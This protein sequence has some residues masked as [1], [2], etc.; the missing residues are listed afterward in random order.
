MSA[1]RYSFRADFKELGISPVGRIP[2]VSG[3]SGSVEGTGARG[4]VHLDSS[5]VELALPHLFR[6]PLPADHITANLNWTR[7]VG[8][9]RI[10]TSDVVVK[11]PN[12]EAAAQLTLDVPHEGSAIIE[13][14][15]QG[16]NLEVV[17][18]PRYMPAGVM[19]RH[20][21]DWLDNA[22]VNG[23]VRKAELTLTGPLQKFP[24][25]ENEGLFLITADIDNLTLQYQ[26]G[27]MPATAL[28]VQAEFR[29]M[30]FSATASSGIVNGLAIEDAAGGIADYRDALLR[31]KGQIHGDVN[32]GLQ[33]IQQSPIGP[34][35]GGLFQ[36]L[37]GKGAMQASAS[38]SLPLKDISKRQVDIDVHIQ[39]STLGLAGSTQQASKVQG[40]FHI[41][42][43]SIVGVGVQGQFLQGTVNAISTMDNGNNV[44]VTGRARAAPLAEFLRLPSFVKIDGEMSYRFTAPGYAQRDANGHRVLFSVDS[45]LMGLQLDMPAPVTKG[46]AT[47]RSIHVDADMPDTDVMQLRG[48]MDTLRAIV[49]LQ[50]DR[51]GW[52]FDRA[53]LRVDSTA[54]A[55][56]GDSGLRIEGNLPE[57][58][59]D[60]WLRLG[61][62]AN[63]S[64][65]SSS[66]SSAVSNT[67][68]VQDILRSANLHV[69]KL[70]LYGYEW[71]DIRAILQAADD[72]WRVD[73][74]GDKAVGQINIPYA[75]DERPLTIDMDRLTLTY[76]SDAGHD[77]STKSA[78]FDPRELPALQVNV[79]DFHFGEHG[80]GMVQA[81]ASRTP[82]GLQVDNIQI[83]SESFKGNG[84]GTWM[85]AAT[86]TQ[87]GIMFAIEST[88]VR[89]SMQLLHYADFIGAKHGRLQVNLNWP[90]GIDEDLLGR[91]SG[92]MEL[93]LNDGQLLTVQPG[94][95]RM[96]GLM[97]IAELPRR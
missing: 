76:T 40:R 24:F 78:S 35:I 68:H 96:L 44:V 62:G 30:G 41:A 11:S 93:Q 56:P 74:A 71:L 57:L 19:P 28:Q 73:V 48:S 67:V 27:W 45:D 61:G 31:I 69:G 39:D 21:L 25:R 47:A 32:Q 18:A 6:T 90:G 36:Q 70:H 87:A 2:G 95:G 86:G 9:T 33:Y 46:A 84:S 54:A 42:N 64:A 63:S 10:Q 72:A 50:N 94:A 83:E 15:A 13:A 17:S 53:G 91:A 20:V 29:N 59:L 37:T 7:T 65:N 58:K 12:G 92:S 4:T 51:N 23:R 8:N 55:L 85:Q 16:T 5:E 88:D 34:A 14:H 60:D 82:Q 75:M 52:K 22:F 66:E 1:P 26:P 81:H 79:K 77:A 97:S 49:R 38:L 89:K 80:F 43:D 3:L